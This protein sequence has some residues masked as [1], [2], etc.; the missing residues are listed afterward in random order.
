[1]LLFIYMFDNIVSTLLIC[2][3]YTDSTNNYFIFEGRVQI[4][5]NDSFKFYCLCDTYEFGTREIR[6]TKKKSF[7]L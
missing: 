7:N 6:K 4:L 5:M 1:M 2:S 3:I